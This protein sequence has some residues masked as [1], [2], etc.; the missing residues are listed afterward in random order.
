MEITPKFSV[1]QLPQMMIYT[2][3]LRRRPTARMHLLF[4]GK[5]SDN[6]WMFCIYK[7]S[8]NSEEDEALYNCS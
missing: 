8:P 6:M 3:P 7:Q 2:T 4:F 5:H 1:S